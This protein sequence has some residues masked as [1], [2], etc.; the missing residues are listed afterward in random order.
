MSSIRTVIEQISIV[1]S[2]PGCSTLFQQILEAN[3]H[4]I[5]QTP[6]FKNLLIVMTYTF[7]FLCRLYPNT[8]LYKQESSAEMELSPRRPLSPLL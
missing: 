6:F 1:L 5:F 8:Y 4:I 3:T 2:H 7:L